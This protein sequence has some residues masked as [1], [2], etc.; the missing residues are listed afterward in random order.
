MIRRFVCLL[1]W[2][3]GGWGSPTLAMLGYAPTLKL[4]LTGKRSHARKTYEAWHRY[5]EREVEQM[6]NSLNGYVYDGKN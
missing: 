5:L 2:L 3:D 1:C 6:R 4:V